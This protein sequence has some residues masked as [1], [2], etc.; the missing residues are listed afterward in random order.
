VTNKGE[1]GWVISQIGDQINDWKNDQEPD[2][3]FLQIGTN[4]LEQ[5][6]TPQV[7]AQR[8]MLLID[9]IVRAAPDAH[10]YVASVTRVRADNKPNLPPET[11]VH[12][13]ALI[14]PIVRT[15]QT[16]GRH[17]SFAD[18][19]RRSEMKGSD[20]GPDGEHPNDSGYQKMANFWFGIVTRYEKSLHA[21][22]FSQAKSARFARYWRTRLVQPRKS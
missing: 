15:Y 10:L 6:A 19:Y 3:I 17:V 18:L 7:A 21:R 9:Q 4:D 8:L 11:A 13:N 1:N 5:G 22:G 14:P 16:L 12:F 20:L 2:L